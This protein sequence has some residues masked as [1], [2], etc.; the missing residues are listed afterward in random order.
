MGILVR[1]QG[2]GHRK[3][4]RASF[5]GYEKKVGLKVG[6]CLLGAVDRVED[7]G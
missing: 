7:I 1:S 3:A 2:K 6:R 4:G 5:L